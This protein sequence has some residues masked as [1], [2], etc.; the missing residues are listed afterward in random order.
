MGELEIRFFVG[1]S[2]MS[3]PVQSAIFLSCVV[4]ACGHAD[5][6]QPPPRNAVDKSLAPWNGSMPKS[7]NHHVDSYICPVA[8]GDHIDGLSLS[9][10][11]S[12]FWFSHG[13]TIH[14]DKC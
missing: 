5:M 7:W 2:A 3:F 6:V 10:G 4:L 8:S 9:N 1:S 11:Q 13:C 12:C 14:C